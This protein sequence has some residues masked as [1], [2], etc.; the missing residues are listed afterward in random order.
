[1][2]DRIPFKLDAVLE[3]HLFEVLF[4]FG[5]KVASS[6][7]LPSL[8]ENVAVGVVVG[9]FLG[10]NGGSGARVEDWMGAAGENDFVGGTDACLASPE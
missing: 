8:P 10:D 5:S 9:G 1:M 2:V 3:N 7:S 6:C 4:R